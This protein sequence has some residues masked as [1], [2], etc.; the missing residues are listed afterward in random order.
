MATP[1]R[2]VFSE[3]SEEMQKSYIDYAMS[4]IVQRALPDVRDGLKPVQRR[5]LYDMYELG[6]KSDKPYRKSARIVGDTMGKYH[7]HGDSSIYESLVV[8]AQDFKKE[9][10][11]VDG[12]GNFGSIEGDGAAAMRYTEARLQKITEEAYLG[13]LDKEV[14]NFVSNFDETETEPEVLPVRIPNLLVNGAEGIAVGM[15]TSIPPHN[16]SEV[17][18]GV[19]EYMKNPDINT[20]DMMKI[21]SGPDFPTGGIVANKDELLSIYSTGEGK[22]RI[23]GRVQIEKGKNGRTNIV[24]TEIPYTMI[25]ANIGKFLNDVYDLTESHQTNDITDIS[26]MSSKEG[27]RIVIELKKGADVE[28]VKNLLYK[29]TRL[30]DTFGVN[31]LSVVDGR[32]ETMGIVPIIRHSVD[33]Q[34]ELVTKK[35]TYLLRKERDKKEIQEGLI[36]ACDVIDL[37]IEILR[38]SKDRKMAKECLTKGIID[39][40]KF[41]SEQSKKDAQYLLFTDRQADAILEMHLYKLIGLEIDALRG[42]YMKTM[43][44]IQ[45]YSEILENR[46]SMAKVIIKDLKAYKEEFGRERR[47]EICNLEEVIVEEK[48]IEEED[49]VILLDRFAYV[50][51][52]DVP[53]YERNK[54]AA[55]AESKNVIFCK[56]IDR[57][58]IFTDKGN[59]YIVKVL[60]IP[61]RK[62]R[63]KGLPLDNISNFDSASEHILLIET[64]NE[65]KGKKVFFGTKDNLIKMVDGELF[66]VTRK[67]SQAT[68]LGDN[69]EVIIVQIINPDDT[70]AVYSENGY[71]LRFQAADV[72]EKKKAALGVRGMNTKTGED[73]VGIAIL[74]P[75]DEKAVKVG[76]NEVHLER[77]HIAARNQRGTKR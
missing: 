12:H 71:F 14:V 62:F 68:K 43:K 30:E 76:K 27:I 54:E 53:T 23:R 48:P 5:T 50:K 69:D 4:V 74:K 1:E 57:L 32:P 17:I 47:T 10:P 31:M 15:A 72:P 8:M 70:V 73:I 45:N 37:I 18:D 9:L 63:E 55:D 34:Y 52:I 3:Y 13:D 6:I 41:K 22:I 64:I 29:K 39:N 59:E 67:T 20:D 24:V 25:G 11:L 33:F 21:I 2:I 42:D 49:V 28:N 75:G 38:G 56:N 65:L 16:L 7:P 44:N 35:Y 66:D 60:D 51:V 77:L 46:G 26:N 19:I 40:V 36:K 58:A 61:Q